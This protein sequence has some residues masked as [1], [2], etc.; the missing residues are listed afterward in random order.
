MVLL[1]KQSDTYKLSEMPEHFLT[2]G[3]SK[4]NLLKLMIKVPNN[5]FSIIV[6]LINTN[7]I[8]WAK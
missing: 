6:I 3:E 8:Q 4:S 2:F 1:S 5:A 7:V